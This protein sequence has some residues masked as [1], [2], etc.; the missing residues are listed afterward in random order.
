MMSKFRK[1]K[2]NT[3]LDE[4]LMEIFKV[5]VFLLA[6]SFFLIISILFKIKNNSVDFLRVIKFGVFGRFG[7]LFDLFIL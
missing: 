3:E 5:F 2:T 6:F 1:I 7:F 4:E